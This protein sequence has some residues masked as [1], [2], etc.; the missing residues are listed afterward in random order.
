MPEGPEIKIITN[1]LNRVTSGSLIQD[2]PDTYKKFIGYKAIIGYKIVKVTCKG[3]QIFFH[4]NNGVNNF[5]LNSRLATDGKWSKEKGNYPRFWMKLLTIGEGTVDLFFNDNLNNGGL[6][7]FNEVSFQAK[8]KKLGPDLLSED[9]S[10]DDYKRVISN[11]RIKTN[12]VCNF[13]VKQQYFSGI[14]NY[15]RAEV[16]YACKIKPDRMLSELTEQDKVNL[17]NKSIELIKS[18][19][20]FKGLTIKTYWAPD[21][22]KGVF[23][24]KV[25]GKNTDEL[26]NNVVKNKYGKG[27]G[28]DQYVHWVPQVQI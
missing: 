27:Q 21:G 5:Y 22:T 18:S 8:L 10:Y 20:S 2:C 4:L 6:D 25:Y 11:N 1:W 9:V 14:G 19:Y 7:L 24:C 23:P 16:L 13:L 15:L 12:Y 3:K 28:A 17:Y 26:G